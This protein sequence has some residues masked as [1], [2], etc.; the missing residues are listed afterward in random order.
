MDIAL[1]LMDK[2]ILLSKPGFEVNSTEI[3]VVLFF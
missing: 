3:I 1:H 2:I